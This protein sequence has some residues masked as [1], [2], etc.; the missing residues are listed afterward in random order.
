MVPHRNADTDTFPAVVVDSSVY[1]ATQFRTPPEERVS[2]SASVAKELTYIAR[3]IIRIQ[4]CLRELG[5]NVD[6]DDSVNLQI[7]SMSILIHESMSISSRNYHSVQHVFD[8]SR[9]LTDPVAVLAALFHDCIY[10]HVDGGLTERQ[11]KKLEGA[12][13]T[14]KGA[15]DHAPPGK[16]PPFYTCLCSSEP[17]ICMVEQIFGYTKGQV[18]TNM[19]GLNEYLS[20]VIAV[21]ELEPFLPMSTLAE[22]ATCIECTIPFRAADKETG[23][24]ATDKLYKNLSHVNESDHLGMTDEQVVTAVQRAVILSNE[25]VENFGTSD[26]AWFLDNTWSLLTETNEALRRQFLYSVMEFQF[27][28]FKMNGF[29]NFLKPSVVFQQFRNIPDN[30]EIEALISEARRNLEIGRKYVGAKLLSTSTLAAFAMLTGGD[31]PISLFMGDLPSRHRHSVQLED[32]LPAPSDEE[33][34]QCDMDVYNLLS[35]GRRSETAFDIKESPL[36]AYLYGSLGDDGLFDLLKKVKVHPMTADVA[37]Q[38]LTQLPRVPVQRIGS[39][40]AMVAM[41][42]S[43]RILEVLKDLD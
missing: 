10:Y 32:T 39:Q 27:A 8:I 43:D 6:A 7:E 36:A 26:R 14:K 34:E 41:S 19:D 40:M 11:R 22:I 1:R 38:L 15:S 30:E 33:L 25:D 9:N 31:A 23:E 42:R 13:V 16:A 18:L 24:T 4:E 35:Q 17:L 3:L 37:K 2:V 20:A 21:R 12:I 5:V 29:F 28:V